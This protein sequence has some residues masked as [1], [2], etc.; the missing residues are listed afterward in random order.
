MKEK[1][2][3]SRGRVTRQVRPAQGPQ[4]KRMRIGRLWADQ[5]GASL[6]EEQFLVSAGHAREH[7]A[8]TRVS[9]CS[10]KM[11]KEIYVGAMHFV[12]LTSEWL[13]VNRCQKSAVFDV[14]F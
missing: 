13:G 10:A 3:F 14:A 9:S 12:L 1:K 6:Q 2:F 8:E 7:E 5:A 4:V 11:S